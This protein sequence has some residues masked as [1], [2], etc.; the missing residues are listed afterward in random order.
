MSR[1]ASPPPRVRVRTPR[2]SSLSMKVRLFAG[3]GLIAAAGVLVF[4]GAQVLSL[5]T[6]IARLWLPSITPGAFDA[7][8]E[9]PVA[10]LAAPLWG[11]GGV[12][13]AATR[14]NGV[15]VCMS[16]VVSTV[17]ILVTDQVRLGVIGWGALTAGSSEGYEVAVRVGGSVLS[18]L[19]FSAAYL[20][21]VIVIADLPLFGRRRT[22]VEPPAVR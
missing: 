18:I 16:V 15:R 19:G 20:V 2:R 4:L 22:P 8:V 7:A 3:V 9:S 14:V 1:T 5:E 12:I 13:L 6:E 17:L 10:F 21:F 11:L